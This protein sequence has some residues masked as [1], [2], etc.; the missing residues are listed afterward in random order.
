MVSGV[1]YVR[2]RPC[3]PYF[4]ATIAVVDGVLWIRSQHGPERKDHVRRIEIGRYLTTVPGVQGADQLSRTSGRKGGLGDRFSRQRI[5]Y[6]ATGWSFR[7]GQ[8]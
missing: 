8:S 5:H 3:D 7:Q 1:L 6:C 2:V 4:Q